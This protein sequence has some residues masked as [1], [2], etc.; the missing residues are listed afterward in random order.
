MTGL[1]PNTASSVTRSS[2]SSAVRARRPAGVVVVH[3]AGAPAANTRVV[4]AFGTPAP[5]RVI[6]IV[7]GDA[8]RLARSRERRCPRL[9]AE[10]RMRRGRKAD[11][12][13]H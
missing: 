11:V 3:V 5:L 2:A 6:V 9:G 12:G 1:L 8:E 10:H 13:P 4:V 7:G